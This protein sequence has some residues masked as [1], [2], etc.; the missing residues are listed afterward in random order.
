MKRFLA[1]SLALLLMFVLMPVYNTYALTN[2]TVSVK[3]SLRNSLAE[4]DISFVADY[5]LVGGKD[6]IF[7]QFPE[8]TTLPC[9]CPHNWHL[10]FFSINGYKPSRAGKVLNIPNTMYLCIPGGITIKKGDTVNVVIKPQAN[11]WNPSKPGK[12]QL[13]LWTTKD[14][15]AKSN[16]YEITS[17]TLK[18]VKVEV[19][20][21]TASL[22][23]SYKIYFETGEKGNLSNGQNIYVMFPKGTGFPKTLNKN[24]IRVNDTVP[25][26]VEIS[27][28]V[29]TIKISYSINNNRQCSIVI[30][31][32][33]GISNPPEGGE[34][35]LLI[36]TDNEPTKVKANFEIKEQYTVS[37][38]VFTKPEIPD[39]K[40]GFFVTKPVVTLKGETNTGNKVKT[41]YSIDNKGKFVLYESPFTV[42]DG[43]HTLYY[44][45]EAGNLKEKVKTKI[46]K[47]DT[48]PPKIT[49]NSPNKNP[50]YTGESSVRISGKVSE[51]GMLMINTSKLFLDKDLNF[52]VDFKLKPGENLFKIDFSD[53]AGNETSET[54]KVVFNTTVPELTVYSPTDWSEITS[55]TIPIKGKVSPADSD[56]F[57][58]NEKVTVLPDG[59]FG[60]SFTPK[61]NEKA[62]V[63]LRIK[64]IYPLSQKSSEKMITVLYNPKTMKI[65][66]SVGSK[67]ALVNE[68]KEKMDVAPFIDK[69]SNRTLVPV[70]FVVEFL[71]GNVSWNRSTRTVTVIADGKTVKIPIGSEVAFVNG[72]PYKLDQ[73]AIILNNRTFVPL[74]FIAEALG[75]KVIWNGQDR[76]I[77]I[78]Y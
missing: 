2:L 17:T 41:Y 28:N 71:G 19:S 67:T 56:L 61:N 15:K 6:D 55:R 65:I 52:S 33:F 31:S 3:P 42:S 62:V 72:Q 8:G 54:L 68:K 38:L 60:Y 64:A 36:W 35:S 4:Y 13:V 44:Y 78:S 63:V 76:T 18:N 77:T 40:N 27:G 49:L 73:P 57:I 1:A 70:R 66:L 47:V 10:E 59:T 48:I 23:A 39:G 25:E 24:Y 5:D 29:M 34:K 14:A 37:T 21:N 53:L 26:N 69:R 74:R 51:K 75:F 32:E 43:I 45:S 12:Y 30:E 7:I 50:F 16:F 9:S 22:I 11:I 46:F 20:P 58:N